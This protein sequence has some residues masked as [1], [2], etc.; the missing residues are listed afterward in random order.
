MSH[1]HQARPA[2]RDRTPRR[3]RAMVLAMA[4]ATALTGVTGLGGGTAV[5]VPGDRA[6]TTA[7]TGTAA[8]AVP[9][10][11]SANRRAP[12]AGLPDWSRAGYRGGAALPGPA[13][14]HPD[15]AC[16]ITAEE[17]ASRYGV[18]ADGGDATTG[19]QQ[20]VDA[21]RTDCTPS[22]GYT[23]LSSIT[24]PAGR[25]VVT[26]QLSLD[27]DYM[28][29]R[30]AGMGQTTLAFRPDANT[31]YDTLTPDGGDWDEDG[32]THGAGKGG[33]TW[34]GRGLL[35]V[36]TREVSPK[37]TSDHAS[38]PAD[39]KDIFEGSVNQHWASGIPLREGS[40]I[41]T[42]QIRLAADADMSRFTVGAHL[43]VGAA[44]T[45]KFYQQQTITDSSTYV[46]QHMRQQIFQIAAVDS[47]GRNL[48]L[49]KPLEYEL[50]L[51]STSDGSA[52]I[53][54]TVYPSRVTP[55]KVV[56]GVGIEDLS[57]TQELDG[58]P[59][60]GG[61]TYDVDPD[62]ARTD[63]GNIAPEYAQHGI[64]LKW[65]ANVWIRRVGTRMTG[66]HAVV[67]ESAKNI[68]VQES[69]FDGS[70]NKGKGGNGYF[71]GS[72]VWDSLYAYNTSRN[73]RHF[74]FQWSASDNV[75]VGNDFDSDL[76]LH[77]GW[78]RRNLFEN[79]KAA[80]P[81][82]NSSKN[83]RANCGEEG[84]GGPDDSTWWPIWWGAGPKAVKWSGA[85]G[86]QN[87]FYGNDLSKQTTAGGPYQPYYADRRRLY[88]LGSAAADASAYRHLA[89][90]G[91]PVPDWAGR[92]NLDYSRAPHA[93]VNATRT[94]TSGS[95]FLKSTGSGPGGDSEAP[96]VP[97]APRATGTTADSVS[98]AWQAS[99][100]NVGVT[101]YDVYRGGS[102]V[103]TTASTTYTDTGLTAST[104]YGYTVKAR[105]AAGNGS[106][107][108]GA[109]SATT[110][111]GGGTPTPA[112]LSRGRPATAS[113]AEAAGFEASLAVDGDTGTRWAS[114]EGVDPQ[115]IRV[116][117]GASHA[118]SRVR[119]TWE[120]AY[121]KAYRIQTSNDGTNWTD[122]H[123][124]G[125]GDGGVD[126]LAV[127]GAG[128]YV[129]MLGTARGTAYGYSL[130]EFEV[131]GSPAPGGGADTTAPSVPAGLRATGTSASSVSLAWDAA[132]DDVGVTGY[133]VFRGG[134][135]V[136]STASASYTDTG[137]AASTSY[138]YTVRARDAAGNMSAASGSVEVT[139]GPD[140]GGGPVVDVSTAGQLQS[141][142]A[143]A[144]PGQTI[145]L[146][147]GEYRGS[148]VTQQAGTAA[149]PITLT[150]PSS[151]VLV[152]D[153][154][155]G[156]APS[157]PVPTA[158]WDSGY[159][160][161]LYGAP[162][163]QL[164]GFTVKE[165][166]K[167]V[168]LD[169]S[170]HVTLDG[171]SVH[172]VDE[173]AVHFRRSS[174]DGVIKNSTITHTGLVQAGYGE[175]VYIGSAGSNWACH[176]NQGGVDRS[177][178]VQ[179]LDNR[180]GPSVAAEHVDIKEGTSDG[181][182]RGNTFD[183]SGISGSNSADSWVDA[184]G[185]GYLIENNTGTFSSPGTFANGYETH[186]PSTTPSFP[187]GCG[188]VW[189]GNRS[190]LGGVGAYAIKITSPSK[191]TA[192]P[193]VVHASNTVTHAGSG[194]TNVP[195]TP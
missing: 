140:G 81:F 148:F 118:L 64:V 177:D 50:P 170:P 86:P 19:L 28:V 65:A 131:Y 80:V 26:R 42:T 124:T 98:L 57:I 3:H 10:L 116:D 195:V 154:P 56:Q 172:H 185:V 106:G 161:W 78:E 171:L 20:A 90:N 4:V 91:T 63:F 33:W 136:G 134:T 132:T 150:G 75:V 158:G 157:C 43:W 36:Q 110:R 104:T 84:G 145:R 39:R 182:I 144:R 11:S 142:L 121:G 192:D 181:V 174:A 21:I 163:W 113:S 1:A 164:T 46:N 88:Q 14:A 120:A 178:R 176:G 71:R 130:W 85:T 187:N 18:R 38:A 186:N 77:G 89:E 146:A 23:R 67:T 100:D 159:G 108:S 25:I 37:Y 32:M 34:P 53:G 188:N 7:A 194:L 151:A 47:A 29:L 68:Q 165:S 87:V 101:G 147:A 128:R 40:A 156:T 16:H 13:E 58:M 49:D 69:S 17:L 54:G 12:V 109:V 24:L 138:G 193:N 74:T 45:A 51:D 93:G 166:K 62:D 27:A 95:L 162:Y 6:A 155:S 30:G 83:C 119:L 111:S 9:D 179:V 2:R 126:D 184:K 92:E 105:D 41:G 73:L 5:A 117:L 152:N 35:R 94:D 191:C 122:V 183:G 137:L 8:L 70:W 167:G 153:G 82:E 143:N 175:A 66:S 102:L 127:T 107:A 168:V 96:S 79:N 15:A 189:R 114:A 76:N 173:E 139:T 133:D 48:T 60:L 52:A 115:W 129:R 112:L 123:S 99:T 55:L 149:A 44:N 180:I 103:G 190:D 125:T 169:D 72:R 97:G 141:A 31:R 61:G 160:L 59:R 22:A 135:R